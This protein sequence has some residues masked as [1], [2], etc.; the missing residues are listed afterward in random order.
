MYLITIAII[1]TLFLLD[2][3]L[4]T[5]NYR[6]RTRPIP[7]TVAD[8]YDIGDYGKWLN[9][10]MEK[11][12]VSIASKIV[13]TAILLI[14]ITFNFFPL[15]ASISNRLTPGTIVSTL[16]FLGLYGSIYYVSNIGF[17]IYQTFN[18]EARYG[19]NTTTVRT[20]IS[21]QLKGLLLGALLG[22]GLLSLLLYL[23]L[24]LGNAAIFY[25]WI[26]TMSIIL[27]MNLLYT[28]LFIR[29]FNELT[30]LPDGELYDKSI[31]LATKLGYEIRKISVM[32][33][34]KRSTRIN[35]FFTG[36]G[37]FKSI[38][39]YDTL[40]D[41]CTTDE[42]V[43]V[44]AHEIGHAKHRDVLK[45]L[46]LTALQIGFHFGLL[47]YFLSS[48]PFAIAFG[49]ESIHYGFTIVLFGI[50]VSPI[51]ILLN[52]PLSA[53]SRT[54]EYR[55]DACAADA[56]YGDALCSA[57]KVLARENFANLTP[58]PLVVRLTYSHPPVTQR[59]EA[60]IKDVQ[61]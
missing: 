25:A 5:L 13:D 38:I 16:L 22:G 24:A 26:I 9:Y 10:T 57:L 58:H 43:S 50:L 31:Q 59:I 20:F 28:R 4:L 51:S 47:S 41:K 55:A 39:L 2:I 48:E 37:R 29:L 3:T 35:A 40:L 23:Y 30:P 60:I 17:N 6:H 34:S 32:D 15:L 18:I 11:F 12:R 61:C 45:N 44:L 33:A 56:G 19:F 52:I 46:L 42:I 36:F 53:M 7:A 21:D 8:V 49:F 54:A 27:M 1:I 14:M